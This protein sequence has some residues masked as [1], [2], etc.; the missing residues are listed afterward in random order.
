MAGGFIRR[1][2]EAQLIGL[3]QPRLFVRVRGRKNIRAR[4]EGAL[5]SA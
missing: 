4:L 3:A 2:G 5:K 1:L